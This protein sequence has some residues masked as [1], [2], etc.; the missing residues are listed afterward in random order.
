MF[1]RALAVISIILCGAFCGLNS[2][3][4]L[5]KRTEIC[6]DIEKML[7]I[8]E[9]YIRGCETDVYGIAAKL[10]EADLNMLTFLGELPQSYGESADFHDEWRG[11]V[12]KSRGFAA[13]ERELIIEIGSSL[14]TTDTEGQLKALSFYRE[15]AKALYEQ[16]SAEYVAKGR[17]YRSLGL[18]AGVTAA[19][20]VI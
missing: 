9:L 11:S 15:R 20:M 12:L 8:C 6:R 13:E 18:L 10:R 1:I 14:G 16:R 3:E 4:N 17:L 7:R 2:S 5:R 19:I